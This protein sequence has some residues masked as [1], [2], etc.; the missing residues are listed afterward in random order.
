MAHLAEAQAAGFVRVIA[1][2]L[3]RRPADGSWLATFLEE[4]DTDGPFYRPPGGGVEV[5]EPSAQTVRREI[6]EE[7]SAEVETG[8][9]LGVLENIF[10]FRGRLAHE[11]VFAWECHFTDPSLYAQEELALLEDSGEEWTA[12]WVQPDELAAQGIPLYPDGLPELL[13]SLPA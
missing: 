12:H 1:I 5:G 13:A 10:V 7:L 3:I 8:R 4:P 6:L 2:A 11:I 9:L